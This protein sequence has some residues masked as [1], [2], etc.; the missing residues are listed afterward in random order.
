VRVR[1]PFALRVFQLTLCPDTSDLVDC[2]ELT[3]ALHHVCST[4]EEFE[5]NVRSW[6]YRSS[7]SASHKLSVV[8]GQLGPLHE[9]SHLRKLQVPIEVLLGWSPEQAQPLAE[10]LPS[11]LTH[12][13]VTEDLGTMHSYAWTK[14][15]ILDKLEAF[16]SSVRQTLPQLQVFELDPWSASK[17][18]DVA[19]AEQLDAMCS[20]AGVA[21]L[22]VSTWD[23]RVYC[24]ATNE[25]CTDE[26]WLR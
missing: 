2:V 6:T 7:S 13:C 5:L 8:K 24:S 19:A 25:L 11:S 4:L 26:L 10:I 15:L 21:C 14:E 20:S 23:R 17:E 3:A 16:F 18:W 22:I 9:L 12:L 1:W